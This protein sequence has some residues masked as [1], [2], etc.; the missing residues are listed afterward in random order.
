MS[1]EQ[2]LVDQAV[3]FI[4]ERSAQEIAALFNKH[5]FQPCRGFFYFLALSAQ[6]KETPMCCGLMIVL[7]DVRDD[8]H[9]PLEIKRLT[10]L[11]IDL[12]GAAPDIDAFVGGFDGVNE[13]FHLEHPDM[14]AKGKEV[15]RLSN[16]QGRTP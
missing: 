7:I 16:L 11:G 3:R 12:R 13:G 1:D 10:S 5:G 15:Y 2:A 8:M 4:R 14:Y 6:G 9:A